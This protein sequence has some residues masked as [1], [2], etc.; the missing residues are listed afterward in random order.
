MGKGHQ[1][2]VCADLVPA[3]AHTHV[4]AEASNDWVIKCDYRKGRKK[5]QGHYFIVYYFESFLLGVKKNT[6]ISTIILF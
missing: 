2:N 4:N 1:Q 6:P 5:G 3:D